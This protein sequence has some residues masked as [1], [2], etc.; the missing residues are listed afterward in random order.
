M[1]DTLRLGLLPARRRL[2]GT[3]VCVS[4]PT[5]QHMAATCISTVS[6]VFVYMKKLPGTTLE[7]FGLHGDDERGI[8][9]A[10]SRCVSQWNF[11]RHASRA[12]VQRRHQWE[13]WLGWNHPQHRCYNQ[14]GVHKASCSIRST[15]GIVASPSLH[16]TYTS[17]VRYRVANGCDKVFRD[18]PESGGSQ[19]ESNMFTAV[20]QPLSWSTC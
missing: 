9:W 18:G 17:Q 16:V 7:V 1:S 12:D 13:K 15:E 14:T 19:M 6:S 4:N 3:P 2:V 5:S 11:S 20:M 10:T 8:Y